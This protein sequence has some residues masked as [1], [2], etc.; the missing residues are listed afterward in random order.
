MTKS[1]SKEDYVEAIRIAADDFAAGRISAGKLAELLG[2]TD[3]HGFKTAAH[4]FDEGEHAA[5][6]VQLVREVQSW[7]QKAESLA[8]E[9]RGA[10]ALEPLTIGQVIGHINVKVLLEKADAILG[11]KGI[12]AP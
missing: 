5:D 9:V 12:G 8:R 7:R 2:C 10:I 1:L 4:S 6:I 3:K 11:Q